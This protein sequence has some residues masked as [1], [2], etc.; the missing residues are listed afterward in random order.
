VELCTKYAIDG[1]H[2]DMLRY[3]G[4]EYCYCE[5]CRHAFEKS[6]GGAPL[7]AWPDCLTDNAALRNAWATFRRAQITSLVDELSK[8]ARQARYGLQVSAAVYPDP[9]NARNAVGQEWPAWLQNGTVD[10]VCPMSYRPTAALFKGDIERIRDQLGGR[11]AASGKVRPGI[12]MTGC[13][14][15]KAEVNRQILTLRH[16]GLDGYALFEFNH[17]TAAEL[18]K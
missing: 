10:F 4:S 12:G 7:A 16:A 14:L 9:A 13:A 11:N 2:L 17:T 1:I 6:R 18:T 15:D 8:A 3:A 5:N